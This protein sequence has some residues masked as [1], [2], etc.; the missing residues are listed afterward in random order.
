MTGRLS[1]P[2][3]LLIGYFEW[4]LLRGRLLRFARGFESVGFS[5][6]LLVSHLL[7]FGQLLRRELLQA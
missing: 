3:A 5:L 2:Y 1:A 6:C 4:R 7:Q